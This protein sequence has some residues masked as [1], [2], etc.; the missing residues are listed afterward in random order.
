MPVNPLSWDNSTAKGKGHEKATGNLTRDGD[1]ES[2]H[3]FSSVTG[4]LVSVVLDFLLCFKCP[5]K[6]ALPANLAG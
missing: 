6:E 2:K 4:V 5:E 3:L 1:G